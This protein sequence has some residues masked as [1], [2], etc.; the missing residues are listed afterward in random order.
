MVDFLPTVTIAIDDQPITGFGNAFLLSNLLG[1]GKHTP[2]CQLIFEG[3]I[4]GRRDQVIG[5]NQDM[6]R[7]LGMNVAKGGHQFILLGPKLV[8]APGE[9]ETQAVCDRLVAVVQTLG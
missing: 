5:H 6:G 8:E 7:R 9:D 4:V 1:D 3:D 2:Q